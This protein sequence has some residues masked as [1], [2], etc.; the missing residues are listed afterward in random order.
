MHLFC[1]FILQLE[2]QAK[3]DFISRVG[4][5]LQSSR[6]KLNLIKQQRNAEA[7]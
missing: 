1:S 5:N 3:L 6:Y 4:L 2:L 7:N